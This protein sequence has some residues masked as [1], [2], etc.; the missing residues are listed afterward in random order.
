MQHVCRHCHLG[1][2]HDFQHELKVLLDII[3][4]PEAKFIIEGIKTDWMNHHIHNNVF[5]GKRYKSKDSQYIIKDKTS[6][7]DIKL[8]KSRIKKISQDGKYKYVYNLEQNED[9]STHEF[10][11]S[12]F[13]NISYTRWMNNVKKLSKNSF[14]TIVYTALGLN[15]SEF[16]QETLDDTDGNFIR[17]INKVSLD[18]WRYFGYI[19]DPQ[20]TRSPS[21]FTPQKKASQV[22]VD[23]LNILHPDVLT[24]LK[25]KKDIKLRLILEGDGIESL[26]KRLKK[27]SAPSKDKV[28]IPSIKRASLREHSVVKRTPLKSSKPLK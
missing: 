12:N 7:D 17:K 16:D 15:P 10:C 5:L 20:N 24:L 26:S 28:T 13:E 8:Q 14:A 4:K 3:D 9:S 2:G 27:F 23:N 18:K 19:L 22:I 11:A 6:K 25:S 1:V 21:K